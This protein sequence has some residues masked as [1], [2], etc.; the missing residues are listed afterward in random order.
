MPPS[1]ATGL[2][3]SSEGSRLHGAERE[4][5]RRWGPYLSER[6]WGT[7]RED[8]SEGGTA[9]DYFPHDHARSRMYRWGEDGLAGFGNDPLDWCVSLALWNGLD[10]IIKERLF[11]LANEEGNHGEDVKELY[12][13]LDGTPTHS[14]MRMLYKYP[15]AAYPYEDLIA[16]NKRRG[17]DQAEYEILDTGVFDDNRFFDVYVEY[18][19]HTPDDVVMRVTIE[20]RADQAA[21]LHVMPQFWARNRWAWSGKPGKP[22]LTLESGGAQGPHVVARNP[23]YEPIIVTASAEQAIEWLFCENETN[24]QRIFG[25]EK[26]GPF[27]DG[28]ND[29]LVDDK[30][31]AIRRDAGTRAAAHV[32]LEFAP[33]G[34]SVLYLRWH[35]ESAADDPPLDMDA[36]FVRRRAE[37]DEFYAALQHDIADADARLVQRQALAGMLWSKQYYQFDMTRWHDGDPG[38]PKPPNAR[39][40]G[41]NAD[42]RHMCNGD[43][44]SMPDKWE[45]PW[46]A[47]WDLAFHAA[48]FALIDPDFAKK[49]LLMVVQERYQHPNGQLPAYEWAFG[50]VNPPVHAWATWRVYEIDRALTGNGDRDFLERMFHKLLLNFSWWVN[51]KDAEGRNIFQGGF[52]GL[53]NVGIFDRSST[54][55]T[56]GRLDQ[57]DGTAWM[58][59]YALDL[60]RIG[61]ELAVANKAYIDIAVK[62]FEHFL[63]I[64][65]AVSCNEGCDTG[66]WDD[67]DKFFYD[68]LHLPDGQ[69]VPLRIR[70]VIGLI[71]LFAVHVLEERVYGDLPGLRERLAWFLD[72]RPNLAKLVSRWSEPGKGN[73]ALLSLLR[74]ERM[75]ALLRRALDESEFLSDHGVRSMSRAYRDAPFVFLHD[76]ASFCVKYQPAESD[77]TVFGGNSNWRGPVWMPINYL[78]IESLYEFYRYYGD[79]FRVEYPTNSGNKFSL[80]EIADELAR[81]VTTLFLKDAE[82]LRPVMAAYPVLQADPRSRDLVLFHEY[83][84]GDNGRGVGASHQ[85]GW[86]GLVALLLQPRMMLASGVVPVAEQ[87][88]DTRAS[89]RALAMK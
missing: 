74:G 28:F 72:H 29:Y 84:H 37:A 17:A 3:E 34:R 8:Y 45:Y 13:Y 22:S 33:Q 31:E 4:R 59:A 56:G 12:F 53:D 61:L 64:A 9:W 21:T 58:A 88:K 1:R 26:A 36:L 81:R 46:Y 35:P 5:W 73:T 57:A 6:Q 63:Y 80:R 76:G 68:V 7:V 44:I 41:R 71:P 47:S 75:K 42:W 25:I 69:R 78:L 48:A 79:E 55:P 67:Q 77:T 30:E 38:Q 11:G 70:S 39:R 20:N 19:K 54:L 10:P 16:E 65:E 2:L 60:M 86:S 49:Q 83:F 43:V 82:G 40:R 62:F 23:V 14:Y 50:D 87:T 85:T 32:H 66:L 51:R 18:A 15:H 52:L 24:V 27:K 89:A